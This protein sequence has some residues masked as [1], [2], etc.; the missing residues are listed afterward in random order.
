[1]R[2]TQFLAQ[3]LHEWLTFLNGKYETSRGEKDHEFRFWLYVEYFVGDT[4][5]VTSRK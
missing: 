3:Q 1:M 2:E 4:Q 5:F